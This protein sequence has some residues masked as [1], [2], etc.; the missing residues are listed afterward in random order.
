M[1]DQLMKKKEDHFYYMYWTDPDALIHDYGTTAPQVKT[2]I[3]T[4]NKKLAAL[5]KQNPDNLIIVLADHS[6]VDTTFLNIYEHEDF[7]QCLK[8]IFSIDCR[9]SFFHLKEGY[10][11]QFIEAYNKYYKDFFAIKSKQEVIDE[12]MF[13]YGEPHVLFEDFLGDYLL[14]SISQYGFKCKEDYQMIGAHSGS[15]EEEFVINVAV[16][17][18]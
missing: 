1:A 4:I 2:N 17:N 12:H 15:L 8:S 14:T 16:I 3:K 10:E 5:A 18:S 6:L 9:S 13:G 7:A 11:K